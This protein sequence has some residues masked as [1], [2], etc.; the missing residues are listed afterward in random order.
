MVPDDDDQRIIL[1]QSDQ[2]S[3]LRGQLKQTALQGQKERLVKAFYNEIEKRYKMAPDKIDHD[4]FR[5]SG[6]GKIVYWFVG[7]KEI[8]IIAKQGQATFLSLGSL[9]KEYN[10]VIGKGGAQGIRQYL[11]LPEYQSKTITQHA[12][13]KVM[14]STRNDVLNVEEQISVK[15][16]SSADDL[17]N[18]STLISGVDEAVGDIIC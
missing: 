1:N 5:L 16:L 11:N 15:D 6:D 18:L 7:D 10:R 3:D 9:A 14:E 17:N 8:R 13:R 4:Q 2:I 12:A